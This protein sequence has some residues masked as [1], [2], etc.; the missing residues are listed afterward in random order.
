MRVGNDAFG[1]V[2]EAEQDAHRDGADDK[3]VALEVFLSRGVVGE[4]VRFDVAVDEEVAAQFVQQFQAAARKWHVE[5][6]A[7]GGRGKHGAADA[8]RVVV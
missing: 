6:D 5:F 1:G 3:R 2:V 7:E 8:W 4:V